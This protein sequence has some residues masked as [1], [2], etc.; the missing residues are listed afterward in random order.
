MCQA[1]GTYNQR[2]KL[3]EKLHDLKT[4]FFKDIATSNA[5]PKVI[6]FVYKRKYIIN[7]SKMYRIRIRRAIRFGI[8]PIV[9]DK[10]EILKC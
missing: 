7:A 4:S 9:I 2:P 10:V 5:P 8:I 6:I 1:Y 3:Y